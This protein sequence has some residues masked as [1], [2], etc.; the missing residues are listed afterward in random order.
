MVVGGGWIRVLAYAQ[1]GGNFTYELAT[2]SGL[3]TGGLYRYAQHPSYTGAYIYCIGMLPLISRFDAGYG[4]FTPSIL[5]IPLTASTW[6]WIGFIFGVRF[7]QRV[8][9][10]EDMMRKNF[11]AEWEEYHKRTCRFLPGLF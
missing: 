3:V 8:F 7:P 4:C 5:Q 1:L 9:E 6:I 11:G 10:E 2:P